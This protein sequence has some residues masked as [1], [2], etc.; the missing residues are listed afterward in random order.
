[1]PE[2]NHVYEQFSC[3]PISL[4]HVFSSTGKRRI[5]EKKEPT[6]RGEI[7]SNIGLSKK[8]CEIWKSYEVSP[9][10]RGAILCE[11]HSNVWAEQEIM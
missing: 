6:V 1:M 4:T 11:V 2:G 10:F 8:L 9:P 3:I 7:H 5:G